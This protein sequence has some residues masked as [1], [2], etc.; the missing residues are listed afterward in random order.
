MELYFILNATWN[1]I[2]LCMQYGTL[3][4]SVCNVEP[5]FILS[6]CNMEPYFILSEWNIE[7]FLFWIL[8]ETLFYSVEKQYGTLFYFVGMQ[9][10]LNCT[11]NCD[12]KTVFGNL[13]NDLRHAL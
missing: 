8:Y 10:C 11:E 12:Y 9:Y 5:Y 13:A 7:P 2:L 3:F 6:K 1:P 4:Y